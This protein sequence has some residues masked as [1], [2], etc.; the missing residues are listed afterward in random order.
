MKKS[1]GLISRLL[2]SSSLLFAVLLI[3]SSCSKSSNDYMSG[4]TN[5]TNG[6]GSSAGPGVNQVFIENMA[7]NPS[8]ITVTKGTAIT[9]I[10]KDAINHTVTSD[11]GLFDSGSLRTNDTFSYT[12][13]TAGT[14][15]YHCK[16]HP[17]MVASVSVDVTTTPGTTP[18]T[19][20]GY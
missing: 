17:S 7:F 6:T 3:S 20:P 4:M 12:F 2:I 19:T 13:M 1:V 15:T 8:S 11:A 10:N 16:V 18:S 5:N 9:W 14:F